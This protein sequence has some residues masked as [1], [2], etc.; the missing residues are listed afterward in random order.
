MATVAISSY[1]M[2]WSALLPEVS[3]LQEVSQ[4]ILLNFLSKQQ[5]YLSFKKKKKVEAHLFFK[6]EGKNY[7][8]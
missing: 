8:Y 7:F 1:I 4:F 5:A 6:K 3:I 2:S